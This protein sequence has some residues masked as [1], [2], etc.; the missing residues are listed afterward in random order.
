MSAFWAALI[1]TSAVGGARKAMDE[2]R[3]AT[4]GAVEGVVEVADGFG[5]L[6]AFCLIFLVVYALWGL[7]LGEV[8]PGDQG[9]FA[10]VIGAFPALFLAVRAALS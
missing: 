6:G 5:T 9:H 10:E 8:I 1:G 3:S 4:D 2:G 7:F